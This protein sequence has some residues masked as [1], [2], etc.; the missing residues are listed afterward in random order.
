MGP[1]HAIAG[2]L[3]GFAGRDIS[4]VRAGE[5]WVG[6][7]G[8]AEQSGRSCRGGSIEGDPAGKSENA[9]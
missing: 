7:H 9:H 3:V 2:K 8:K 4:G 5:W 1:A 6:A